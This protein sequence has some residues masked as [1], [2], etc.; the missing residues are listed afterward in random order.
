MR[1]WWGD[2]L[3][4]EFGFIRRK[5]EQQQEWNW[6]RVRSA[7]FHS[8]EKLQPTRHYIKRAHTASR[9][10]LGGASVSSQ[11]PAPSTDA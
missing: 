1:V 11:A 8:G 2:T 3:A 6:Q 10:S 9:K 5:R 4:A 7:W